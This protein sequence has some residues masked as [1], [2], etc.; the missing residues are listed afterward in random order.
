MEELNPCP[1]KLIDVNALKAEIRRK[2]IPSDTISAGM[3]YDLISTTPTINDRCA[4]PEN[5]AHGLE[6]IWETP[7]TCPHCG[8]HLAAEWSFCPECGTPVGKN[9]PLTV[10]ELLESIKHIPNEA[11]EFKDNDGNTDLYVVRL[12]KVLLVEAIK[13]ACA[14]VRKP[15]G[16]R[17]V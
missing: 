11:P 6:T 13:E 14:Y 16:E 2:Y 17:H 8:E 1:M 4:E 5:E 15:E 9:K 12:Y 10:E 3:L 7:N